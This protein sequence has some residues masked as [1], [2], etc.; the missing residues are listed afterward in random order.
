MCSVVLE[1][2]MQVGQTQRKGEIICL[3]SPIDQKLSH[4]TAISH[5]GRLHHLA[6]P[7][8]YQGDQIPRNTCALC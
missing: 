4:E 3:L 7:S 5:R 1:E 8:S 2:F 6:G